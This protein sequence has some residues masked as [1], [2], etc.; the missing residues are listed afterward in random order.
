MDRFRAA[1]FGRQ[2]VDLARAALGELTSV[3]AAAFAVP[4]ASIRHESDAQ[5]YQIKPNLVHTMIHAML[6]GAYYLKDRGSRPK[7]W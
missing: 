5:L 3:P 4:E 6:H 7:V 2:A 1:V